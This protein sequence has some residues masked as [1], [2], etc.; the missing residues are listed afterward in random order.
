M[1]RRSEFISGAVPMYVLAAEAGKNLA[2]IAVQKEI[3]VQQQR[4]ADIKRSLV[5]P[6]QADYRKAEEEVTE[7]LSV[8]QSPHTRDFRAISH[9]RS[10]KVPLIKSA[11]FVSLPD[12][13][14]I[15]LRHGVMVLKDTKLSQNQFFKP[16]D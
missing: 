8:L 4:L 15:L 5:L 6:S 2:V 9:Q 1:K 14:E 11:W 16:S 3:R 7:Y 10:R 13:S 12:S